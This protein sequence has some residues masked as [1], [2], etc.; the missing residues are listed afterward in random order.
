MA[1]TFEL[2]TV[3][4]SGYATLF[5][6]IQ[7][8]PLKV[9]I[10]QSTQMKVPTQKWRLS[11]DSVAFQRFV[12]SEFGVQ[13]F[14]KLNEIARQVNIR[15]MAG[16]PVTPDDVRDIIGTVVL[17]PN[18]RNIRERGYVS[19]A[20]K[21]LNSYIRDYISDMENGTRQ[22]THGRN[23]AKGSITSMKQAMRQFQYYQQDNGIVLDFK[24][25]DML[26]Y[27]E[28]TSYLKSKSYS[29][30]SIGKCINALKTILQTA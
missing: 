19:F 3:R 18:Y 16:I 11:H 12:S 10:R 22:S 8:A 2:R 30:N 27:Q 23:Y 6:R 15:L 17:E 28:Y 9:N 25:I 21:D 13:L 1:T 24:D 7:S 14:C 29:I 5:V 26:F 20:R 4:K